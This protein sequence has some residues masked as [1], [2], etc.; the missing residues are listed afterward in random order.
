MDS[1]RRYSQGG[2][3]S[4]VVVLLVVCVWWVIVGPKQYRLRK[5]ESQAKAKLQELQLPSGTKLLS[6][7]TSHRAG[8]AE[9]IGDYSTDWDCDRVKTFY[10]AELAKSGFTARYEYKSLESQPKPDSI[11]FSASKYDAGL[12][13]PDTDKSPRIYMIILTSNPEGSR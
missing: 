9:A 4:I 13:C 11:S 2:V 6:V 12:I 1:Q 8:W 7:S 10:K 3:L 5:S